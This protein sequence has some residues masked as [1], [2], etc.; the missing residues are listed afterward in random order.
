[1]FRSSFSDQ[2]CIARFLKSLKSDQSDTGDTVGCS[3]FRNVQLC[4]SVRLFFQKYSKKLLRRGLQ[5]LTF[6][7][8]VKLQ[9]S[10]FK[11]SNYL[12]IRCK[13]VE[14]LFQVEVYVIKNCEE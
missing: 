10:I 2:I 7:F 9:K 6:D 11:R 14:N 3:A 4:K 12:W 5:L 13:G 1:M 8:V